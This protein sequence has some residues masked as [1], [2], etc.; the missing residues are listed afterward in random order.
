MKGFCQNLGIKN[1]W[2]ALIFNGSI[3]SNGS[4]WNPHIET[5]VQICIIVELCEGDHNA[6]N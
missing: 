6:N 2:Q 4:L 1:F 5:G 3:Q